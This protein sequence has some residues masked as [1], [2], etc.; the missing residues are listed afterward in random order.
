[1]PTLADVARA[2]GVSVSVVSRILNNDPRLRA[3]EDTR[4]R[5]KAVASQLGYMPNHAARALRLSHAETVSLVVPDATNPIFSEMFRGV[6]DEADIAG[7]Q[8]LLGQS[9]DLRPDSNLLR[10]LVDQGRVDGFVL[11]VSAR[12]EVHEAEQ[13]IA[14][15]VPVVLIHARGQRRGSVILDDEG[16]AQ[17]ATEHLL[18]LGHTDIAMVSGPVPAQTASRREKGYARAMSEAH[19]RRRPTWTVKAGYSPEAGRQAA[20]HLLSKPRRPTAMV[21]A[22]INA[23]L[24]VLKGARESKVSVPDELS[25]VAIHDTWLATTTFPELTT[26]RMPLYQMGREG[27]RQLIARLSGQRPEDVVITDPPPVLVERE[28]T[29]EAPRR[30]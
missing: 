19:V 16:A 7:L 28:S 20:R 29:A 12:Q 21:V 23:A 30:R 22:N 11:Q 13:A 3:R 9:L 4:D 26:V 6:E 24:G 25:V 8:V 27:V 1:M 2:A 15:R 5:V 18:A 10:R 14:D 17:L